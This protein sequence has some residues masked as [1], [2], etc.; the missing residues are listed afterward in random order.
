MS[1]ETA[2]LIHQAVCALL[3]TNRYEDAFLLSEV[4]CRGRPDYADAY[5]NASLALFHLGRFSESKAF[6]QRGPDSLWLKA[7]THYQMA[8]VEVALA[9]LELAVSFAEKAAAIHPR[10]LKAMI[11]DTDL[12]PIW[13]KIGRPKDRAEAK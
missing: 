1:N 9:N 11:E 3:D 7:E 2:V 6:M 5:F 10:L 12:K 4:I 8:C 13:T